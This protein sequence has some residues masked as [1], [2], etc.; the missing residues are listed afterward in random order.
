MRASFFNRKSTAVT[1]L[2]TQ[3]DSVEK[4]ISRIQESA[5]LGADGIAIE[6]GCLA[7]ELR[8]RANFQRFMEAAPALPFMFI[9]YRNDRWL[10]GDDEARQ[11]YLLE[12]ASSGAE[13][14][15]VMGDL[16]DPAPYELTMNPAAIEKQK[17]L[18]REIHARGAK[19][20]MSSHL[21]EHARTGEEVLAHLLEQESRGADI[22][23]I[24]TGVR[25]EEELLEAFRTTM[26]L[27]R[28]LDK[29]F[30]HLCNGKFSRLHRFLG[31]KLGVSI[32]F[33]VFTETPQSQPTIPQL[34]NV[35]DSIHWNMQDGPENQA[36][37]S[38]NGMV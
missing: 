6:L 16:F 13:V 8:T 29:P 4:L 7:P 9:L 3:E 21:S 2:L 20:I 28:E 17:A 38:I 12:A 32:A 26:L 27:H 22:L 19:V 30:V 33:A 10:G 5:R 35:L 34:R 37:L 25:T 23:K 15:D 11:K 18:I 14:I 36:S 1:A 31:P 24:V